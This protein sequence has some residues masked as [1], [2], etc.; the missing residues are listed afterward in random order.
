MLLLKQ[1]RDYIRQYPVQK[2]TPISLYGKLVYLTRFSSLEL[3]YEDQ[4]HMAYIMMN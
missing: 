3:V 2:D 1:H 4:R